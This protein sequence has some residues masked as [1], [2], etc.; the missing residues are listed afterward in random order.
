MLS[1]AVAVL[2]ALLAAPMTVPAET[3]IVCDPHRETCT[4]TVVTTPSPGGGGTS[5]GETGNAR[6]CSDHRGAEVP[7]YSEV[8]GWFNDADGCYYRAESPQ[9]DPSNPIWEG[10]YPD[11]L[12]YRATCGPLPFG[13]SGGG[14]VWLPTPPPGFGD[15]GVTPAQLAQRAV[16]QM[17][18][19]GPAIHL[20][21]TSDQTGLVGVPVWLWTDVTP[22]TWGPNS[23]TASVPGLS[24]TAR[25]QATR[26]AWDM[27]D[28]HTEV[29]D[30]PGTP[31]TAGAVDSPTCDHVY[32][33]SSAGQSGDAFP[34]T[35]TTTWEVTWSGGGT[36][37]ALT[38][39][40]TTTTTVRIGELQVLVTG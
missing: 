6:V 19:T 22:T 16:D 17:R 8:F 3:S 39:T 26:I 5:V 40:R 10:R 27:G 13:G 31:Y 29:C 18:L 14:W 34:I 35:A 24:V 20:T 9:P 15:V 38:L 1:A 12:I 36:S 32:E 30:G 7:C 28:G 23:A 33:T 21:I 25:A 2:A 4:V 11:G 37:G